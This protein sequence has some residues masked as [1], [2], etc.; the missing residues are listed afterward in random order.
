MKFVYIFILLSCFGFI[1][2]NA[3]TANLFAIQQL[4]N[5]SIY[6]NTSN[7]KPVISVINNKNLPSKNK[8]LKEKKIRH[9]G[10]VTVFYLFNNNSP[11]LFDF[12]NKELIF[13]SQTYNFL[14]LF[15]GNEKRGPPAI[16][17]S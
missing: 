7:E 4:P 2:T 3:K 13:S 10:L 14:R 6:E 9:R 15:L 8:I 1:N 11:K 17:L 12:Y 16:L 5:L